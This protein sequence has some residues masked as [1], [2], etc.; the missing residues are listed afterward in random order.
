MFFR[1]SD[2]PL[3]S[4]PRNSGLASISSED[5]LSATRGKV[6]FHCGSLII[7]YL[8]RY[9]LHSLWFVVFD[10][11]SSYEKGLFLLTPASDTSVHRSRAHVTEAEVSR[12]ARLGDSL[13]STHMLYI[14]NYLLAQIG[15][16]SYTVIH[17]VNHGLN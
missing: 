15:Q 12:Y 6:A 8:I 1:L 11:R 9:F 5:N 2:K 4:D 3:E 13:C 16:C 17:L 14:K 7:H 10:Y